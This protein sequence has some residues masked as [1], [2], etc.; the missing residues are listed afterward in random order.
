MWYYCFL[1]VNLSKLIGLTTA[2]MVGNKDWVELFLCIIL[3]A[4]IVENESQTSASTEI[5]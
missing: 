4:V 3:I 5:G 1:S 2:F